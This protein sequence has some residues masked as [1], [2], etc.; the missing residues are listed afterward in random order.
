MSIYTHTYV[1]ICAVYTYVCVHIDFSIFT[2]LLSVA[3][4]E[5]MTLVLEG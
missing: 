5:S 2:N 3:I 1:F 4:L